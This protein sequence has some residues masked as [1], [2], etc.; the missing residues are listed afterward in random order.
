MGQNEAPRGGPEGARS[1]TAAPGRAKHW[2]YPI[3]PGTGRRLSGRSVTCGTRFEEYRRAVVGAKVSRGEGPLESGFLSIRPGD[4]LWLYAGDDLGIVGKAEVTDTEGRPEPRVS[5]ALDRA[6]SRTLALDPVPGAL[7]RR[8]LPAPLDHPIPLAEHPELSRGFEWW[9]DHLDERDQRRLEPI[10]V[11]S[12]RQAMQRSKTILDEPTFAGLV[13]TLRALDLALGV[14]GRSDGDADLVARNGNVLIVGRVV[15]G[16]QAATPTRVLDEIG[17]TAW[18]GWS[19]AERAPDL[20]LEPHLWFACTRQPSAK[21]IAFTEDQGDSISW[22]QNGRVELGPRTRL[23]WQA[24]AAD[25]RVAR[26][27]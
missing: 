10:G 17:S 18:C 24:E 3:L 1:T 7:A 6:A 25:F 23:R 16:A 14:P 11:P 5:F 19:L 20:D 4:I 21:L 22:I 15:D 26:G 9:V 8:R 13:R 2:L 12:L 27:A